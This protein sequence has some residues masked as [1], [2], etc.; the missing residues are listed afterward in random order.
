ML[1]WNSLFIFN[2]VIRP[3]V[4]VCTYKHIHDLWSSP[5]SA[6]QNPAFL[7]PRKHITLYLYSATAVN[8]L[9]LYS[10]FLP[11][12]YPKSF[13]MLLLFHPYIATLTRTELPCKVPHQPGGQTAEP[14]DCGGLLCLL[15]CSCRRLN[16]HVQQWSMLKLWPWRKE[17]CDY[18]F[19]MHI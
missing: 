11:Y 14:R 4:H 9:R 2:N 18:V 15:N 6:R 1:L 17:L 8:R 19:N 7:W 10:S 13:T 12:R 5:P 16:R 3:I